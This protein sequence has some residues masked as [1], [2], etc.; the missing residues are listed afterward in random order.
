MGFVF[1]LFPLRVHLCLPPRHSPEL[2]LPPSV[3][4]LVT[5]THN[6]FPWSFGKVA[7]GPTLLCWSDP[8]ETPVFPNFPHVT[9]LPPTEFH[10]VFFLKNPIFSTRFFPFHYVV[11]DFLSPQIVIPYSYFITSPP[12]VIFFLPGRAFFGN[13]ILLL[14]VSLRRAFITSTRSCNQGTFFSPP[15]PYPSTT[16]AATSIL[17]S[18]SFS[19]LLVTPLSPTSQGRLLPLE[20]HRQLP[21]GH[22]GRCPFQFFLNASICANGELSC[23]DPPCL[24]SRTRFT[25]LAN[26]PLPWAPFSPTPQVNPAD[27]GSSL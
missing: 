8:G 2:F 13:S 14:Y 4:S 1:P 21:S 16:S 19:G 7:P 22:P 9:L 25:P 17:P 3:S 20:V 26:F 23:P 10:S 18:Q 12:I 24:P 11:N 27:A 15:T 5:R 6:A